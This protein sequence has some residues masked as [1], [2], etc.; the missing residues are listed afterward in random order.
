M[1]DAGSSMPLPK[2]KAT[3]FRRE[4]VAFGNPCTMQIIAK[5]WTDENLKS[6]AK[7]VNAL[8]IKNLMG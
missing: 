2:F 1:G 5:H 8:L 6:P 3:N 4:A 7:Y